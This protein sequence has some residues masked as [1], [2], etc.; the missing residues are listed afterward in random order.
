MLFPHRHCEVHSFY[1]IVTILPQSVEFLKAIMI[2]DP[3]ILAH[4][5]Y[6]DQSIVQLIGDVICPNKKCRGEKCVYLT[7]FEEINKGT[8]RYG[9]CK[10]CSYVLNT[11]FK[12]QKP[13][14]TL[15]GWTYCFRKKTKS[16]YQKEK[17]SLLMR[18]YIRQ[19]KI[20][21]TK[22]EEVNIEPVPKNQRYY[23]IWN[24]RV[25]LLFSVFLQRKF[26]FLFTFETFLRL[27]TRSLTINTMQFTVSSN[28]TRWFLDLGPG[29]VVLSVKDLDENLTI[30]SL[31]FPLASWFLLLSQRQEFLD[32]HLPRVPITPNQQGTF[33]LREE[34]FSSVGAQDTDTRGHEL[35]DLEDIEFSWEDPALGMDS[36][37]RPGFDTLF[38]PSIL[39]NFQIRSTAA[40]PIIVGDEEDK[41]NSAP[42][43]TTPESE[44]PIEHLQITEK[45]SI[46][47]SSGKCASLRIQ[48][49]VSL[50]F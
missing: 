21:A 9:Q 19:S 43:T 30:S 36:V 48:D 34:V 41:E 16:D 17:L 23:L 11:P 49:S 37:Y 24:N 32:N 20:S 33:E 10:A 27:T 42:T 39:D 5:H 47:D 2:S 1:K 46:R 45:S 4:V 14:V 3:N 8:Y 40:N 25:T 7:S 38:S 35:S 6:Q 26:T 31:E 18:Q 28:E 15:F 12:D 50:N 29:S 44:R 13:F 22:A